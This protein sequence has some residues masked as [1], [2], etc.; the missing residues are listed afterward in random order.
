MTIKLS[1]SEIRAYCQFMLPLASVTRGSMRSAEIE[2]YA[3]RAG[4]LSNSDKSSVH[5]RDDS[6]FRN[7]INNFVCHRGSRGNP[8][9]VGLVAY[10]QEQA[11]F[12][13]KQKGRDFLNRCNLALGGTENDGLKAL[14]GWLNIP[15]Q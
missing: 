7:R 4:W 13:L 2:S 10:H 9:R 6:R 3:L 5:S 11:S 8:I 15:I 1:A 14:R 12:E